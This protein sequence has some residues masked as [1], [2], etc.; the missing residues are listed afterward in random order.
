MKRFFQW[1]AGDT[2]GQILVFD[3]IIEEDDEVFIEFKDGSRMNTEFIAEIN[4][5]ELQGKMMAEIESPKN[6]WKFD[7]KIVGREEE[8][9]ETDADGRKQLVVPFR[10][11]R[12]V[13]KLIP[14]K[15]TKNKFGEIANT[16]DLVGDGDQTPNKSPITDTKETEDKKSAGI[17]VSAPVPSNDPVYIMMERSKKATANISLSLEVSVPP[18]SL[19]HVA[20]ESFDDGEEKTIEYIINNMNIDTIKE[21][22]KQGLIDMYNQPR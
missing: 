18:T 22:I 11:G 3:K 9:W 6:P 12:K 7:E 15:P 2:K 16:E 17:D 8:R 13:V 14:P 4:Q 1:I 20:K 19:F 21:S 5:K 10:P